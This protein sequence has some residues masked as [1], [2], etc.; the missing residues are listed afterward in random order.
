MIMTRAVDINSQAVSPVSIDRTFLPALQRAHHGIVQRR[1][2]CEP[3]VVGPL[4]GLT[5]CR[6]GGEPGCDGSDRCEPGANERGPSPRSTQP[7]VSW[8]GWGGASR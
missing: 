4:A 2:G 1:L 3:V 7:S 6:L 5:R 8:V